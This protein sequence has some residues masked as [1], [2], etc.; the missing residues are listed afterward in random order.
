MRGIFALLLVVAVTFS[1]S[2]AG[3]KPTSDKKQTI[4]KAPAK[5][6]ISGKYTIFSLNGENLKDKDFGGKIPNMIFN[7]EEMKYSTH[8]GCNQIGGKYTQEESSIK[9]LP[10]M[11]TMMACPDNLEADYLKALAKVDNFKVENFMLNLYGGD[12]LLIV[13]QPTKR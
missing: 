5:M 6:E 11:S 2:T 13:L 3:N 8:I 7:K 1:C 10:G 4:E 12:E 9:F